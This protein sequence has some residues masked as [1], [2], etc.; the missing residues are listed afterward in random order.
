VLTVPCRPR[1]RLKYHGISRMASGFPKLVIVRRYK[2]TQT[3]I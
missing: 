1:D 2:Y 3:H